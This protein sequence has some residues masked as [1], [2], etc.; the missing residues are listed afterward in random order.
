MTD[1]WIARVRAVTYGLAHAESVVPDRE[2]RPEASCGPEGT[3]AKGCAWCTE[4]LFAELGFS[5]TIGVSTT[6]WYAV[7]DEGVQFSP[8]WCTHDGE[9]SGN[10]GRN[11]PPFPLLF[12]RVLTY[13]NGLN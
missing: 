1:A 3:G 11:T 13:K 10:G 5:N 6:W 12:R 7:D 9:S 2:G 8:S 4:F